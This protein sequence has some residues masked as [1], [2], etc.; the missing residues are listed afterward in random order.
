MRLLPVQHPA[1]WLD[2]DGYLACSFDRNGIA[3]RP[4]GRAR[5]CAVAVAQVVEIPG[6]RSTRR[7][8]D[9]CAVGMLLEAEVDFRLLWAPAGAQGQERLHE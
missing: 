6:K 3:V 2:E 9:G 8:A 5:G 4:G 1:D 7:V